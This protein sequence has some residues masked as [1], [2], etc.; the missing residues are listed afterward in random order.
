MTTAPEPIPLEESESYESWDDFW[1]EVERQEAAERGR[2]AT[3]VIRGVRV[4]IPHD[5]TLRFTR[6][7]EQLKNSSS[8]DD[9]RSL[10][11][12]LFG[13]DVFDQWVENGMKSREFR[14]VLRWAVANANGRNMSFREAYKAVREDEG[15]AATTTSSTPN[16]GES[17]NTG[18]SSRQI[19][20]ASTA[21]H[22]RKS[23][24]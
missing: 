2:A 24:T 17:A 23:Q 20:A 22:R 3:T 8:D 21:S 12:D 6:K 10:L 14:V 9:I 15:K 5:L 18:S 19:S 7:V 4:P 1:A 16:S 11:V 13:Q